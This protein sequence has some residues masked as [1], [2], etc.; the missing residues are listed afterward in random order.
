MWEFCQ[1]GDF[2]KM[3]WPFEIYEILHS[4]KTIFTLYTLNL[5]QTI[6][7]LT[8]CFHER[9]IP[10]FHKQ[11]QYFLLAIKVKLQ[12]LFFKLIRII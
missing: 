2:L 4:P 8:S 11:I 1:M 3:F 10:I 9:Q 7:L 5:V 12:P 6:Q